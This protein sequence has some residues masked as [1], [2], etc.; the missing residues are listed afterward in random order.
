MSMHEREEGSTEQR[1]SWREW[2]CSELQPQP[3]S[4][5]LGWLFGVVTN[6]GNGSVAVHPCTSL[7]WSL[8]A[9]R[10]S[11]NLEWGSVSRSRTFP[12]KVYSSSCWQLLLPSSRE[13]QSWDLR[14]EFQ[15]IRHSYHGLRLQGLFKLVQM[16]ATWTLG[17]EKMV[18]SIRKQC[19]HQM[20][21]ENPSLRTSHRK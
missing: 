6:W 10:K 4:L 18:F 12:N 15:N 5:E 13:V 20:H 7:F 21:L 14:G 19:Y 9:P 11:C 16:A 1:Q 17:Y 8:T 2:V 3:R